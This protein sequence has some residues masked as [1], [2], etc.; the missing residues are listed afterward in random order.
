MTW[1]GL[2]LWPFNI[3]V[4]LWERHSCRDPCNR[5]TILTL[6]HLYTLLLRFGHHLSRQD[7]DRVADKIGISLDDAHFAYFRDDKHLCYKEFYGL[8]PHS[9]RVLD[10]GCGPGHLVLFCANN[11]IDITGIDSSAGMLNL[12]GK[13]LQQHGRSACLLQVDISKGLPFHKGTFDT[14]VCESVLNHLDDPVN[15]LKEICRVLKDEGH[16]IL[17]VSNR[18]GIAWRLA[19]FLSQMSGSYPKGRIHWISPPTAH[20][21]A[22]EAGFQVMKSRGLHFL[23]PPK[24]TTIDFKCASLL[25]AWLEGGSE[26]QL[27]RLNHFLEQ[28][29]PFNNFCFKYLLYCSKKEAEKTKKE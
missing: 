12:T 23:P 27:F 4:S 10:V 22:R 2:R 21:L 20:R 8:N 24:I 1:I 9:G 3:S 15:V 28:R 13:R 5:F 6:H 25:P 29:G 19:I 7:W 17:D 16:L 18:W 26:R 14:I 11:A